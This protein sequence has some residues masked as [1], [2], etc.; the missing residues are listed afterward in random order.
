MATYSREVVHKTEIVYKVP[1]EE[2]YGAAWVEVMKAIRAAHAELWKFGVVPEGKDA[3]DDR[4]WVR[5]RDDEIHVVVPLP[6]ARSKEWAG[7]EG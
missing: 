4:I 2:P 3:A 6:D 7:L 1:A 5:C